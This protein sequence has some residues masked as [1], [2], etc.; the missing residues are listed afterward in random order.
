MDCWQDAR[1]KFAEHFEPLRAAGYVMERLPDAKAYWA[2]HEDALR[3]DFPPE[4]FFRLR[5]LRSE[6]VVEAQT[7][8]GELRGGE[9]LLD[10]T[11][12]RK[13]DE[14]VGMFAGEQKTDNMYR[15]W[16]TNV[17]R[18]HRRLGIY[19]LILDCTIRYTA[20]LGFDTIT[21]EHAPCN[22]AI[23]IAK[24]RAGFRLFALELDPLA[25]PSV[26]LRYFH[27]PEHLAAYEF[28]C[29]MATL[30]PGLTANGSGAWERLRAQVQG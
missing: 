8:L 6:A 14:L 10:L 26:I 24:L 13:G 3:A 22:N 12:I 5:Q 27:N 15:M 25:G 20:G 2:L 23:I 17:R 4:V 29:G 7:R 19:K 28:R 11:A 21:S 16:H 18:E 30:T 9:P 1:E